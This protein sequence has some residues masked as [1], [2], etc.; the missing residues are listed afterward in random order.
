VVVRTQ[1]DEGRGHRNPVFLGELLAFA[2]GDQRLFTGLQWEAPWGDELVSDVHSE[3]LAYLRYIRGPRWLDVT[4]G[5]R[6]SSSDD[7]ASGSSASG[8]PRITAQ[9]GIQFHAG[10]D[11]GTSSGFARFVNPHEAREVLWR[12]ETAPVWRVAATV[13]GQHPQSG[14]T[15]GQDFVTLGASATIPVFG[16]V[17]IIPSASGPIS[18][19][20]RYDWSIGLEASVR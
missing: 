16:H 2:R 7:V 19:S 5:V 8:A 20:R 14:E 9:D 3:W 11:H 4:G 15:N 13:A 6:F 1:D 12:V 17:A 10:H 18:Q